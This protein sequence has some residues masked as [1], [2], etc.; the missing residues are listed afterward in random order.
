MKY[1]NQQRLEEVKQL[2]TTW[3]ANR[4]HKTR[5]PDDLWEAAA[6]LAAQYSIHQISRALRLNHTALKDQVAARTQENNIATV[7]QPFF[8][9]LPP[10]QSPPLSECLIEMENRHGEKMRMHFA[11]EVS[12]DLLAVSQNFWTR[13]S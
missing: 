12:L 5:I 7:Q 3:R 1:R 8:L 11:G 2:F 6:S 9:E 4:K 13:R 10:P